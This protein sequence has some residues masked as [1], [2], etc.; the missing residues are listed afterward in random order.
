ME[1]LISIKANDIATIEKLKAR[2]D[3]WHSTD[4]PYLVS[5][6]KTEPGPLFLKELSNYTVRHVCVYIL[7]SIY[8][9]MKN[10][11]PIVRI[12]DTLLPIINFIIFLKKTEQLNSQAC[13]R[14][15]CVL[16]DVAIGNHHQQNCHRRLDLSMITSP[17]LE[18]MSRS[19]AKSRIS[20][21][22]RWPGFVDDFHILMATIWPWMRQNDKIVLGYS[23]LKP[24]WPGY[25]L[26]RE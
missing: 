25:I 8:V 3:I 24:R 14:C 10:V 17:G 18:A 12:L 7:R 1:W 9:I 6:D 2:N 5:R 26:R 11:M 21:I 19:P 20:A 4:G 16:F 23:Y 15:V 13:K 22:I